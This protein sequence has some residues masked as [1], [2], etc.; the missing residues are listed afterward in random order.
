VDYLKVVG[1]FIAALA[2]SVPFAV[3]LLVAASALFVSGA[4]LR[5]YFKSGNKG[6]Y[7]S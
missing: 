7:W 5:A 1:L 4:I 6:V 2:L 3:Y